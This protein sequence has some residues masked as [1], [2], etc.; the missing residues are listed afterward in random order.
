MSGKTLQQLGIESPIRNGSDV[1]NRDIVREESYNI[2]QLKILVETNKPLLVDDQ[3][4]VYTNILDVVR[5]GNGEIF[6]F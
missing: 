5:S 6:F 1:L 2:D 3:K 4:L